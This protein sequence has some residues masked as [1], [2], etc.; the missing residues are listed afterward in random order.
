MFLL[1]I[2]A[3]HCRCYTICIQ[4]IVLNAEGRRH[5]NQLV[6]ILCSTELSMQCFSW[7]VPDWQ[8]GHP[9]GNPH[10]AAWSSGPESRHT[11]EMMCS[12]SL[13]AAL[14][15]PDLFELSWYVVSI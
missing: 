6:C 1:L 12:A 14:E 4:A 13:T 7:Y 3:S 5:S 2:G 8:V 9:S 10:K 15:A 11:D